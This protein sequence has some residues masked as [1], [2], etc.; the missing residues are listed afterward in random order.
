M[1]ELLRRAVR[2]SFFFMSALAI[3]WAA[4][5]NGR[6][7]AAGLILGTCASVLNGYILRRRI[8][9]IG[10][11][12]AGESG[13]RTSLGTVSRLASVLLAIMVAMRYPEWFS[14]PATLAACFYVQAA[15]FFTAFV[16]NITRTNGKG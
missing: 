7:V 6:M 4:A 5:P 13:K 9:R 15:V 16:Q 14:L 11:L 12:A 8:E 3:V 2:S 10:S 1:D